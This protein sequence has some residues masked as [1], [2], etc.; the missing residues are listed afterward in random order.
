MS[1]ALGGITN[2]DIRDT[3]GS[4]CFTAGALAI[5]G[6]NTENVL[7]TAAVVHCVN[8]VFQTDLAI[9]S[10]IDI[11]ALTVLSAKDGSTI[12]AGTKVHPARSA[13]LGAETLYYVLAC[14]GDVVYVI[15]PYI[16]VAAAQD[17][18][19]YELTCPAGYA[20]FGI[21]KLVRAATDTAM[22]QL[23]N[24]TAANGDL[25]ATGRT[26]T[27]FDVSCLPATAAQVATV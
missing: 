26:A 27:F 8:G 19:S 11:S 7:T 20:P 4:R 22:F 21:I 1:N 18:A 14:K 9:D 13:T 12:S 3:T 2:A 16:D 24:G 25:D 15:E 5:H 10:E 6:S 23:G 17:D